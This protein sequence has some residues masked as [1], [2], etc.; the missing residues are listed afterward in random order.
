M[1]RTGRKA[2]KRQR[3]MSIAARGNERKETPTESADRYFVHPAAGRYHVCY[4]IP[5]SQTPSSVADCLLERTARRLAG[6]MN[7]EANK[8]TDSI[9]KPEDRRIVPG[10]Y[11]EQMDLL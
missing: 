10:F 6:A 7:S 11:T 8:D 1:N 5:G 3:A 2:L 4:F 9:P